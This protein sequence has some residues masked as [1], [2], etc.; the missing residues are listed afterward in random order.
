MTEEKQVYFRYHSHRNWWVEGI[1]FAK[2]TILISLHCIIRLASVL[3]RCWFGDRKCIWPVKTEWWG[4]GVVICLERGADLHT[5]QLMPLP[6]TVS[7]FIIIQIGFT[8]LV[9]A[10]PGSPGKG[11]LNGC[12][13][14]CIVRL[15]RRCVGWQQ[16][17]VRS[18]RWS[19]AANL[20][21]SYSTQL[22]WTVQLKELWMPS[23]STRARWDP[24]FILPAQFLQHCKASK[25]A[26]KF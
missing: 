16:A 25:S 4:V 12:V 21:W 2:T 8:Y 18:C 3:W 1:I 20:R 13:C 9:P 19:S 23:G 7:C 5:A 10:Y 14:V 6:H 24:C 17:L 15:D 26:D 11:P 22:T